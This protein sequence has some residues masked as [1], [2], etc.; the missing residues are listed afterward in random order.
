MELYESKDKKFKEYSLGMK[1]R[2]GIAGAIMEDSKIIILD[3]PTNALDD[4]SIEKLNLI[5]KEL[6]DKGSLVIFTSHD[7]EELNKMADIII[8]MDSG[9]VTNCSEVNTYE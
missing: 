6:K 3:E 8:S 5:M 9:R 4:K 1:Q 2:L 7:S